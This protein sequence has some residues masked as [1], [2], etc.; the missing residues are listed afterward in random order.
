MHKGTFV[1]IFTDGSEL[2]SELPREQLRN[3]YL[4][5]HLVEQVLIHYHGVPQFQSHFLERYSYLSGFRWTFER[6]G[7]RSCGLVAERLLDTQVV[8]VRFLPGPR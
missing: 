1:W 6:L 8:E 3:L 5:S 7:L 2:F 4:I